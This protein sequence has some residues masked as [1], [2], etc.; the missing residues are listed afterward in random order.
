MTKKSVFLFILCASPLLPAFSRFSFG[1][2]FTVDFCLLFFT[3]LGA[4]KLYSLCSL[5]KEW[6]LPIEL[7][8]LFLCS[9]VYASLVKLIMPLEAFALDF[10]MCLAPLVYF[11]FDALIAKHKKEEDS[12]LAAVITAAAFPLA[13]SL[14]RELL[15]FG[16]VTFPAIGAGYSVALIPQKA[17]DFTRFFGSLPGSSIVLG[18]LIWLMRALPAGKGGALA[19]EPPSSNDASSS[20]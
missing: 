11:L 3:L 7:A 5:K 13:L 1:I 16:A 20:E 6:A 15:Y 8:S 17:L 4:R 14:F 10:F 18:L 2:V 19:K 12:E 9:S